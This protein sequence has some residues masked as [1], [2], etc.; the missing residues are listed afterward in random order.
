MERRRLRLLA[1]ENEMELK[2]KT[3]L[4]KYLAAFTSIKDTKLFISRRSLHK[5]QFVQQHW[6]AQRNLRAEASIFAQISTQ[7]NAEFRMLEYDTS[8]EK[9]ELNWIPMQEFAIQAEE[10][11]DAQ[12]QLYIQEA[13]EEISTN[14]DASVPWSIT[15]RAVQENQSL[16]SST[17]TSFFEAIESKRNRLQSG[18]SF[19][20]D[21]ARRREYR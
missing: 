19:L 6:D 18:E 14:E 16:E 1:H 9:D 17:Q 7:L 13:G 15:S 8:F 11:V 20:S 4:Q 2:A 10:T 21:E 12:R 5:E 3:N